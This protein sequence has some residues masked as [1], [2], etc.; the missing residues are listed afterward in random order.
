MTLGKIMRPHGIRGELR[1]RLDTA[2]PDRLFEIDTVYVGRKPDPRSATPYKLEK[3]RLHRGAALL[4]LAG[5][6][7]RSQAD[8]LRGRLVMVP[9]DVGAPL[10]EG[11]FYVF[12]LLG[13]GVY[14]EAGEYLGTVR[15]ILETGANDVF[16]LDGTERGEI[17]IPDTDEVIR[18]ID[19]EARRITITPIPGLLSDK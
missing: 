6:T 4:T 9:L 16:L 14:T 17:L 8:A 12:E 10:E 5:I 13:M 11:E 3:T 18:E 2:Y 15:R 1:M 19:L 7:D